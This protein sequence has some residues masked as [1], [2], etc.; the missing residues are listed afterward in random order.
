MPHI[1]PF[2]EYVGEYESW[3]DRHLW[4]YQSELAA[5]KAQLPEK[6]EGIEIGVGTGRFAGPLGIRIGVDPSEKMRALAEKRGIRVM[7]ASAEA[8]PFPDGFFDHAL[9]VTTICFLEDVPVALAEAFRILRTA[10]VLVIGFVDKESALGREYQ[11]RK[12]TSKF[13][14]S[15]YF[16][17]VHE[18]V[19]MAEGVGFRCFNCVQT[20]FGDIREMD[21]IDPVKEGFGLGSFV[22]I[23]MEKPA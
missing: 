4:M 23:K 10:G 7:D 2:E 5:I 13:Y 16:Y 12:A 8:L 11:A 19:R 18:I 15:A 20:L 9:M 14:R 22:V 21:R 6:G 3:F 17:S 1:D